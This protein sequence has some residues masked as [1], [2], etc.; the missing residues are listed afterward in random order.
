[1]SERASM[2]RRV[3]G[4]LRRNRGKP[5]LALFLAKLPM[6]VVSA[7]TVFAME[8]LWAGIA[9]LFTQ[10]QTIIAERG[11]E[12]AFLSLIYE[13][14]LDFT[15]II[16]SFPSCAVYMG[17][18]LFVCMPIS[19]STSS[20]LLSFLR[21]KETGVMDVYGCF[22]NKYPK[23]LSGMLYKQLWVLLWAVAIVAG[24]IAFGVI[25]IRIVEMYA[26]QLS[27]NQ[28]YFLVG[29][30]ALSVV[31]FLILL[32]LF[33][34]RLL[35]YGL[36]AICMAAQP[37]LSSFRAVR[38][39]RKLMRGQKTSLIGLYCS[40]VNFYIPA[41]LCAVLL[42]LMPSIVSWL[43]IE[44]ELAATIRIGLFVVMGVNMLVTL[45]VAPYLALSVRA[46][47]IE[48]KREALLDE[49]LTP[50]DFASA[51]TRT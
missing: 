36:T 19:V 17:V 31:L 18:Y 40:F 44:E 6:L 3:R 45:Y 13:K 37:R 22:S 23:I 43:Q 2:K 39:S 48:R 32:L 14:P 28:M 49:E 15:A 30:I 25:G 47:Y 16:A 33:V 41:I 10:L 50:E 27:L 42:P 26:V 46:F 34:N 21:G 8:S 5:L 7:I 29:I 35:A 20:F 38:L 11:I 12:L 9:S 1:M 51:Q 24:P 4:L